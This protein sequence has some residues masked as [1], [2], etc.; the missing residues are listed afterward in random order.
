MRQFAIE[1]H[2]HIKPSNRRHRPMPMPFARP[3]EARLACSDTLPPASSLDF[4]AP[5][6]NKPKT[7]FS[8]HPPFLPLELVIRRMSRARIRLMWADVFP[9]RVSHV[10]RLVE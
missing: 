6:R 8:Q 5:A 4:P 2:P 7:E 10:E 1:V 3:V 9:T